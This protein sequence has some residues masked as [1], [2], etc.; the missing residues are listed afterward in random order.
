MKKKRRRI[1]LLG[2]VITMFLV[3]GPIVHYWNK[4]EQSFPSKR[5]KNAIRQVL[6]EN[7]MAVSYDTP[8]NTLSGIMT[9]VGRRRSIDTSKCP[10]D[11]RSAYK[12]YVLAWDKMLDQFLS[13]PKIVEDELFKPLN[14]LDI[15]IAYIALGGSVV[16][17]GFLTRIHAMVQRQ[18]RRADLSL[19]V[20][21]LA[22]CSDLL[23]DAWTEVR[24]VSSQHG[25][26]VNGY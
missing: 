26:N 3:A 5:E 15:D 14:E 4:H 23:D 1:I 25:I 9:I 19:C 2:T 10:D 8:D 6:H 16:D 11:F 12:R 24:V 18:N 7:A 17:S 21:E 13:N 20:L 22:L